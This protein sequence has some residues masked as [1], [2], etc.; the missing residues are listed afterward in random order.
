MNRAINRAIK[1]LSKAANKYVPANDV[2]Y[3]VMGTNIDC[4]K[5]HPAQENYCKDCIDEAVQEAKRKYFLDRTSEMG[6]IYEYDQCGFYRQPQ[7]KWG[8]D[9]H[10]KG[11][12]IKK[13]KAKENREMVIKHLKNKLKK[14]YPVS[15]IFDY[16]YYSFGETDDFDFCASCGVIFN[17]GVILSDQELQHYEDLVTDRDLKEYISNPYNAYM[18]DKIIEC[19]H[20]GHRHEKRIIAIAQ[21]I[22]NVYNKP[23][24]Q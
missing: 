11:L 10:A 16:Q 13:V 8:K 1:I 22:C 5:E 14:N 17:Q 23:K 2:Y 9:G 15:I 4:L 6:K 18:L 19:Y 3:I 21:R 24:E 12:V 7:Y 20:K